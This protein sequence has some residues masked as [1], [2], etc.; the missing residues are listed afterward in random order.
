MQNG[1][2]EERFW[3]IARVTSGLRMTIVKLVIN[4]P[5]GIIVKVIEEG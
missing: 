2:K 3:P 1:I 4:Q 5:R